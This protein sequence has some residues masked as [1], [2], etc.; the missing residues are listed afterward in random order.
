MTKLNCNCIPSSDKEYFTIALDIAQSFYEEDIIKMASQV[1]PFKDISL[2][3]E[4][5]K[6]VIDLGNNIRDTPDCKE[7]E[8]DD[9]CFTDSEKATID[10]VSRIIGY[11][12]RKLGTSH[13]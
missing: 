13:K 8:I 5:L 3:R 11:Y 6:D 7:G 12:S 9:S 10:R 2:S 1:N 4:R